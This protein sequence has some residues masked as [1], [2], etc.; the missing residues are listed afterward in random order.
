VCGPFV[1]SGVAPTSSFV[2]KLASAKT[3]ASPATASPC[4]AAFVT[5]RHGCAPV[6]GDSFTPATRAEAN[7]EARGR[8]D[9]GAKRV[10]TSA[11][12]KFKTTNESFDSEPDYSDD[13][14]AESCDCLPIVQSTLFA[15]IIELPKF[16]NSTK[17]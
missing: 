10:S 12:K 8:C 16:T 3:D 15:L 5:N 7:R 11:K 14:S 17:D 4:M 1:V 13:C 2:P 9:G 6:Q